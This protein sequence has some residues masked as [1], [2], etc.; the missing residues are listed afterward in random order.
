MIAFKKEPEATK[1]NNLT[2]SLN[3]HTAKRVA[4]I[5]IRRIKKKIEDILGENQFGFRNGKGPRNATGM[6]RIISE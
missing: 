1:Y 3:A 4:A 6:L 5:V 2:I